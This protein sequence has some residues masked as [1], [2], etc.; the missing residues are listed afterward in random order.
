MPQEVS[1]MRRAV[2]SAQEQKKRLRVASIC[3]AAMALS[4]VPAMYVGAQ[5]TSRQTPLSPPV[6]HESGR[7]KEVITATDEGF[8]FRAYVLTWREMRIV[9]SGGPDESSGAGD[10]LD[11]MV[12]RTDANGHKVLRFETGSLASNENDPT[13]ESSSSS[14][15]MTLGRAP[16]EEAVSAESE[17]Y[18]FT[19][20]FVTWHGKRVFVVDPQS[21]PSRAVGE[22][23]DFRVLRTGLGAMQRLSFSM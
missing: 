12:Y 6:N 20:Y 14:A 16:V 23:I 18:R 13:G 17:G 3:I 8:R 5:D 2:S 9:V 22:S 19:G 1:A 4:F 7:V 11:I 15:S 10:S 21:G